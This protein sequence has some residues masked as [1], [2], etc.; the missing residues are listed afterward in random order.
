MKE[1]EAFDLEELKEIMEEKGIDNL[2]EIS[3]AAHQPMTN[4]SSEFI[5]I[6][7]T[8][9]SVFYQEVMNKKIKSKIT[10]HEIEYQFGGQAVFIPETL[11]STR[12][13]NNHLRN[14]YGRE[15][16]NEWMVGVTQKIREGKGR[17]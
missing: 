1:I 7:T 16:K 9:E 11:S 15:N 12:Y 14:D 13:I 10:E 17:R 6:N 4:S 2:S 5:L 8:G 3:N